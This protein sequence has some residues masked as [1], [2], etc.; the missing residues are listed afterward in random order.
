MSP[1][2]V[3]ELGLLLVSVTVP[4]ALP[5]ISGANWTL[6]LVVAPAANVIGAAIPVIVKPVPE[7]PDWVIVKL[8]LPELETVKIFDPV[9]FTFTFPKLK[10]VG[11]AVSCGCTPVPVAAIVKVGFVASLMTDALPFTAPGPGGVNVTDS[12][13]VCPAFKVNCGLIPLAVIPA[14]VTPS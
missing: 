14:P 12:T 10:D 3:G 4:E 13:V 9:L 1:I 8:E 6:K 5:G 7:I 2:V 11:L